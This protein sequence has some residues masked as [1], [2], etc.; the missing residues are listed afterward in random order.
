MWAVVLDVF[1]ALMGNQ[2]FQEY[3]YPQGLI[4]ITILVYVFNIILISF[5]VAMFINRYQSS[6]TNL[7]SIRRM[8]IIRLKNSS[9]F[10]RWYGAITTT[11]F[12]VSIICMPFMIA[13]IM[14]KSERLNDLVLKIQYT[15]M[16]FMYCV[17]G[18][19]LSI[20]FIPILYFK[21]IANQV[22]IVFN[23]KREQYRGQNVVNLMLTC[24]TSPFIIMVS[25]LVDLISLPGLLLKDS[26][27]FEYKY[28][29][30]LD[31]LSDEQTQIV[32][33]TFVKIFYVNFKQNYADQFRT[34]I[35]LMQMHLRIFSI[36]D[37]LHDL[38]C[39]GNKDY[40]DALANV[41]DYNM[42]KILTRQCSVPDKTGDIKLF[43]C[44]F[45]ILFN[46]QCDIELYNYL[47]TIILDF[48]AG[49]L[50]QEPLQQRVAKKKFRDAENAKTGLQMNA[51]MSCLLMKHAGAHGFRRDNADFMNNFWVNI[52]ARSFTN[53]EEF[54]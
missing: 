32:L 38:Y 45:N 53:I 48:F 34:M 29:T 24:I 33:V 7:E 15:A 46:L 1:D 36:Q 41:Q 6:F 26:K 19:L 40:R 9:S 49:R 54:W 47:Q 2:K 39:R 11:F 13:L 37:N 3:R 4:F 35:E 42:T 50:Q 14:F 21:T 51:A 23:N 44:D 28:Q 22:Y 25:L 10:N 27:H 43:T 31:T 12:P 20:V 8:N 16:M 30:H 17:I 52:V 5:L 18:G